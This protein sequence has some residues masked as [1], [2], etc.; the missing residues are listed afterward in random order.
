[1]YC[2]LFYYVTETRARTILLLLCRRRSQWCGSG[3]RICKVQ[4]RAFPFTSSS[5]ASSSHKKMEMVLFCVFI[6]VVLSLHFCSSS[7]SGCP[8]R[9]YRRNSFGWSRRVWHVWI[10]WISASHPFTFAQTKDAPLIYLLGP[11]LCCSSLHASCLVL[12]C[13]SP[14]IIIINRSRRWI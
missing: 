11:F 4:P 2:K 7:S 13:P 10:L 12:S 8:F 1:M 14:W 3:R 6:S 9:I 5:W